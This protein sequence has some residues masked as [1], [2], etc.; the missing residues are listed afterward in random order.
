MVDIWFNSTDDGV[1]YDKI[2]L[3]MYKNKYNGIALDDAVLR[4]VKIEQ[5]PIKKRG[6]K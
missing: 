3:Y 4:F 6:K 2:L 5:K 1:M